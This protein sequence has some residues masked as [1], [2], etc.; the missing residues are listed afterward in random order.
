M[1][2][3]FPPQWADGAVLLFIPTRSLIILVYGSLVCIKYLFIHTHTHTWLYVRCDE[4]FLEKRTGHASVG[5]AGFV[6]CQ[7]HAIRA[8]AYRMLFYNPHTGAYIHFFLFIFIYL[9]TYICAMYTS[10]EFI[11]NKQVANPVRA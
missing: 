9:Y 7:G 5:V 10:T 1:L 4:A 11:I 8:V 2:I 6:C 3:N